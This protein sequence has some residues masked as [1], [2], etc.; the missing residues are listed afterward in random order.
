MKATDRKGSR[1]VTA[2]LRQNQR[3]GFKTQAGMRLKAFLLAGCVALSPWL[4]T[5]GLA[6]ARNGAASPFAPVMK[7]NDSVITQYELEQRKLFLMLLRQPGD[8]EKEAMRG[9]IQDRLAAGEA[10]RF[11]VRLTPEQISAGMTEF[12]GRANL[13]AEQLIEALGQAGVSAETFR[14]F[15]ANGLL[16]RDIIR[17]RFG[18]SVTVSE[19][20][21]DRA[22]ATGTKRNEL[23]LLMSEL[24]IPVE[25][26]PKDQ[27]ALASRLRAEITSEAAFASAAQRYSASPSAARGGRLDWTPAG[28]LPPQVVQLLLATGPGQVSE[29]VALPNAIL[30]FQ[31]RDV[32][33]DTSA[34]G[35][36][37]EVEYAE[38]LLPNT[39]DVMAQAMALSNR[40]DSC[41]D[42]FAEARGLPED[43][44]TVTTKTVPELTP[45]IALE[46]AKLDPG[47]ASTALTRGGFRVYLMLCSRAPK[48]EGPVDRDVIRNQLISQELVTRAELYLEE[49]RSEAIIETP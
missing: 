18:S 25:G 23:Q 6:Q 35:P 22:I 36:L 46:L 34:E 21:V 10:R 17:G 2:V 28:N 48:G 3:S 4:A 9:L 11:D 26:D 41:K 27:L 15:V 14:D 49:L 16:W 39:E 33:E 7:I 20:E 24:A 37:V 12:A 45:E 5:E 19:A 40:I 13:T 1:H 44:L 42:L 8:P 43:R 47:E 38:Y 29:P 32:A 31:L 30:L